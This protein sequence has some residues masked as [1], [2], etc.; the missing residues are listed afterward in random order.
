MDGY[1]FSSSLARCVPCESA[2]NTTPIIIMCVLGTVGIIAFALR[3][4][5]KDA[6]KQWKCLSVLKHVDKGDLKVMWSTMQIISSV[7]WNLGINFPAPFSKFL[8]VLGFLQLDFLTL[9]CVSG[10]SSFY[11]SS[12]G[13]CSSSSIRHIC[14]D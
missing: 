12:T 4:R 3:S 1:T 11:V 8:E 10:E 9:D 2:S 7:Q 6:V 13:K 5:A 14:P